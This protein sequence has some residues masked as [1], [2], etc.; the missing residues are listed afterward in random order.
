MCLGWALRAVYTVSYT[1][2]TYR[3]FPC[4]YNTIKK[5]ELIPMDPNL[6]QTILLYLIWRRRKRNQKKRV[7]V[8]PINSERQKH[9]AY[10]VLYPELRQNPREF[11]NYFK[12][13]ISTFDE[14]LSLLK[15]KIRKA[16]T[17][18]RLCISATERLVITIRCV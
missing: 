9:G 12:M 6:V 7:W 2:V 10:Y 17:N 13:S 3:D 5:V 18:M 4:T 14:L 15:D 16:D 1:E 11:F 8:Q